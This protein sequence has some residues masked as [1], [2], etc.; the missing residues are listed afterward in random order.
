MV[1]AR[2]LRPLRRPVIGGHAPCRE[3][4]QLPAPK[5]AWT[6]SVRP[7][8][9]RSSISTQTSCATATNVGNRL[10][11][12]LSGLGGHASIAIVSLA[13]SGNADGRPGGNS[14]DGCGTNATPPRL[15]RRLSVTA[16]PGCTSMGTFNPAPQR[17]WRV[18]QLGKPHESHGAGRQDVRPR[19]GA[20]PLALTMSLQVSRIAPSGAAGGALGIVADAGGRCS[21]DPPHPVAP[22]TARQPQP[23]TAPPRC[24]LHP[25]CSVQ[26]EMA[27]G[28]SASPSLE[29][30]SASAAS[31]AGR[32][33]P[34]S[35]RL[36]RSTLWSTTRCRASS[37]SGRTGGRNHRW[38]LPCGY[39]RARSQRS[40]GGLGLARAIL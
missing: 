27:I 37:S 25:P 36:T 26:I 15:P 2:R 17:Q 33:S 12:S 16:R 31:R 24:E 6:R 13:S 23:T 30:H 19:D 5:D 3:P 4:S 20:V 7:S 11:G 40:L 28:S 1:A 22:T 38:G 32:P 35:V 34:I 9:E 14:A 39:R 21:P 18:A 29:I 10:R 8:L